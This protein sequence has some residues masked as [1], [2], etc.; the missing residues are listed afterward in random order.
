MKQR[1][2]TKLNNQLY[3]GVHEN[4]HDSPTILNS[5]LNMVELNQQACGL[6]GF[7]LR[8][9]L[10]LN[11]GLL[12][13]SEVVNQISQPFQLLPEKKRHLFVFETEAVRNDNSGFPVFINCVA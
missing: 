11:S 4:T 9:K 7:M 10:T 5:D 6:F 8:G 12:F 1:I 2:S 13:P 3:R